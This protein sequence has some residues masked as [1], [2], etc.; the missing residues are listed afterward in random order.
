M[1]NQ[2]GVFVVQTQAAPGRE[3]E[4]AE[5]YDSQHLPEVIESLR[6][7]GFVS[8]R[9][10]VKVPA[11]GSPTDEWSDCLVIYEVEADNLDESYATMAAQREQGE[12]G[13]NELV[14]LPVRF[15]FYAEVASSHGTPAV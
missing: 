8:A 14:R 15:H 12:I 4:Y 10:F 1:P 9:R 5:W 6:E 2:R 7:A 13:P 11:A 3:A